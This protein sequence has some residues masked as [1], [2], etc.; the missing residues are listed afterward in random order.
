MFLPAINISSLSVET[1]FFINEINLGIRSEYYRQKSQLLYRDVTDKRCVYLN[2]Y[3]RNDIHTDSYTFYNIYILINEEKIIVPCRLAHTLIMSECS[4][5][6][7][8]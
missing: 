1:C 4:G 3:Y 7:K 6:Y 8:H 2:N 5:I